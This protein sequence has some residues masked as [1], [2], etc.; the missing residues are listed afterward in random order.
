MLSL[1]SVKHELAWR[2]N[3]KRLLMRLPRKV[4]V[5]VFLTTTISTWMNGNLLEPTCKCP[6][7]WKASR[8]PH[9]L[10]TAGHFVLVRRIQ[11]VCRLN[12]CSFSRAMREGKSGENT[13]SSCITSSSVV[14]FA[15]IFESIFTQRDDTQK[16]LRKWI[17]PPFLSS[18]PRQILFFLPD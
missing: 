2:L 5:Y 8:Q 16:K 9:R 17:L 13:Q 10:I 3:Q 18:Y 4:N 6:Q 11:Y 14:S 7:T 12:E 1:S 15:A